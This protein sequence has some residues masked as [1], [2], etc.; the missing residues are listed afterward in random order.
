MRGV[1]S[2]TSSVQAFGRYKARSMTAWPCRYI[3]GGADLTISDLAGRPSILA[4][5]PARAFRLL[6]E[7]RLVDHQSGL[8][9]G[10]RLN[11]IVRDEV[12]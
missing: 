8:I 3:G 2:R 1:H 12:A 10:K 4:T 6:E 5:D 11:G 9:V 7:A